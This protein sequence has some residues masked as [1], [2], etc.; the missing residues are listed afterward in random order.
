ML[1]IKSLS[2]SY[3]KRQR[4]L[5]GISTTFQPGHIYGLLGLNGEGKT[6]LLKLMVGLLLPIEGNVFFGT[7]KSADR[8]AAYYNEVFYLS[9][10][11]KLPDMNI[12]AFGKIYGAFY[13]RYDHQE[14][15]NHLKS[16]NI[17]MENGLRGLSL[18]QH[19]KVHLAFALA[20]NTSVL[21]M[22]EPSNGLDIPSKGIFRK[23]LAKS[24]STDKI[25]VIATHQIRDVDNLFDHLLILN[26]GKL[27][28][29]ANLFDLSKEYSIT[30][31]PE[32]E[33]EIVYSQQEFDGAVHLVK[34]TAPN[35]AKL[36]IEFL[37]NAFTQSNQTVEL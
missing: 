26:E 28:I 25:F 32:P 24:M 33:D 17:P 11:S 1:S 30:R 23:L 12:E 3:K 14:Y 35:E 7:L 36:D 13:T 16:F 27:L 31:T 19:R 20:C 2:Y 21:L 4:V 34:T 18:G 9:D 29:D 8:S 22:D 10:S 5:D 6:T 15:I 37:F